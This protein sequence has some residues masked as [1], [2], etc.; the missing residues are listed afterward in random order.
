MTENYYIY[1]ITNKPQG[2]LYIGITHD[3][4]KRMYEHKN[5][6]LKGFSSR[7][8]LTKLVYFEHHTDKW[9]A[10]DEER[11]LKNWKRQWKIDLIEKDNPAWNDLYR[12]IVDPDLRQD[13]REGRFA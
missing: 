6:V 1:V 4:I 10:A 2:T 3:L 11:K 7:Y 13:A 12:D 5:K 8:N 9:R